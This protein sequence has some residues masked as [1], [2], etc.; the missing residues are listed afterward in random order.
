MTGFRRRAV[1]DVVPH[2]RHGIPL[3]GVATRVDTRV[4]QLPVASRLVMATMT[5]TS[6]LCTLVTQD[7]IAQRSLRN[8]SD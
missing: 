5:S 7:L 1:E 2:S 3:R 4:L 6:S 8:T